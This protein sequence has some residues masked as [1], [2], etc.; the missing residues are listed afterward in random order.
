MCPDSLCLAHSSG[1]QLLELS[2]ANDASA[3]LTE[4]ASARDA[5][6]FGKSGAGMQTL[7]KR[8]A[9]LEEADPDVGSLPEIKV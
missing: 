3:A 7:V 4:Y 1:R 5:Y 9:A 2:E 6:D 8:S